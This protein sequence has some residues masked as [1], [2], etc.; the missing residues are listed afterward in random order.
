MVKRRK[1][2]GESVER[3][4]EMGWKKKVKRGVG[5]VYSLPDF[6]HVIVD[7][8]QVKKEKDPAVYYR[9]KKFETV[10]DAQVY[11]EVDTIRNRG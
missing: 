10:A 2:I 3:Q 4:P 8:R 11:A 7:N 1:P 5:S 9:G 6:P